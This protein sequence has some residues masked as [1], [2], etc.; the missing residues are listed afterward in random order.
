MFIFITEHENHL[1]KT[2]PK[3]TNRKLSIGGLGRIS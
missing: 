1:D 2:P 3:T